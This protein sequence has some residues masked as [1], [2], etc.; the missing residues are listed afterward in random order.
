MMYAFG[1]FTCN[2]NVTSAVLLS[3]VRI[4]VVVELPITLNYY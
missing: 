2:F 1:F 4:T 3:I